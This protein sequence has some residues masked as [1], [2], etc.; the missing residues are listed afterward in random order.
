MA[1]CGMYDAAGDWLTTVG[2]PAKSGVSGGI[3]GILP[4]QLGIAVF[5]RRGSIRTVRVLA[6]SRS[7]NAFQAT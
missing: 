5:F 7:A 6:E 1:T 4:G 3:I 2:I